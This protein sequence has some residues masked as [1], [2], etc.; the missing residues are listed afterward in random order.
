MMERSPRWLKG[1]LSA[2]DRNVARGRP[3]DAM[4]AGFVHLADEAKNAQLNLWATVARGDEAVP[5]T[6]STERV[7]KEADVAGWLRARPGVKKRG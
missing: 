6:P 4:A 5:E 7:V 2:H 3:D 1:Y